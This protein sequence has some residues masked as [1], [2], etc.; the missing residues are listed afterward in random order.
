MS[1]TATIGHT[2]YK[3]CTTHNLGSERVRWFHRSWDS[4]QW[5]HDCCLPEH[6]DW[7]RTLLKLHP[8]HI[9][10]Q[11]QARLPAH[12]ICTKFPAKQR[13]LQAW[14]LWEALRE[15]ILHLID[16]SLLNLMIQSL[17]Q[18]VW[19]CH[20]C[21]LRCLKKIWSQ[22]LRFYLILSIGSC[23]STKFFNKRKVFSTKCCY[24]VICGYILH[25]LL[26]WDSFQ[27]LMSW[28]F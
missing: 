5:M 17:N 15:V 7:F 23:L 20:C 16:P 4:G 28:T 25:L 26:L 11:S 22:T 8:E 14:S 6:A 18:P 10:R 3:C 19:C 21:D 1:V 2:L 24:Y 9:L 27:V 12:W 13:R